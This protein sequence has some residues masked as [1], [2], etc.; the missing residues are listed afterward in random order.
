MV[1]KMI[2]KAGLSAAKI[3]CRARFRMLVTLA[4]FYCFASLVTGAEVSVPS[5]PQF[6]GPNCSGVA[7]RATPP[8]RI[9]PTNSVLWCIEVPW[10]PSSP[11]IWGE[12]IFVTTFSE[13]QLQT[14]CYDRHTGR[15]LWSSGLK[16]EK[17][18]AF[19]QTENSP[20]APTPATDG[21]HVVS[22]SE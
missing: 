3:S 5:W 14:R 20:A 8:V 4:L 12:R 13:G 10:S 6:R 7:A 18:E 19:N 22:R 21:R 16:P 2:A 11:C 15:L 1:R 9:G 17:L